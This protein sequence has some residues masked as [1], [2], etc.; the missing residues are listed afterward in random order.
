MSQSMDDR[1][2]QA[3]AQLAAAQEAATAA[4]AKLDAASTTAHSADRAVRVTVGAKGEL[5]SLEF[6]DGK[7]RSM[8]AGQLSAAVLEAA[9]RARA[10]MARLVV[11][12][13]DPLSRMTVRDG[14][15][16]QETDVDWDS[17]FGNL[18]SETA[19]D[20]R[21]TS[22]KGFRDEIVEDDEETVTRPGAGE[23][24]DRR[25]GRGESA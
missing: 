7:Y 2:A 8:A 22:M 23:A 20:D 16:P 15:A 13:I 6:L 5:T 4:R 25:Q 12:T 24:G 18:L 11:D 21:S 14:A 19:V 9:N 17:I 10:E 1:V 3:M